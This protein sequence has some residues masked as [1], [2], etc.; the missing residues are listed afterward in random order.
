MYSCYFEY[1]LPLSSHMWTSPCQ[2]GQKIG[3]VTTGKSHGTSAGT[4]LR[5]VSYKYCI[6]AVN[7][8]NMY[9]RYFGT[10]V[11]YLKLMNWN[12]LYFD[13]LLRI[14]NHMYW[15]LEISVLG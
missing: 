14:F 8:F 9:D 3:F 2:I 5:S 6:V 1:L 15:I 12:E 11:N 4:K 7:M 10:N 13:L